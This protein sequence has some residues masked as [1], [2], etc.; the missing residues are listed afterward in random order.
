VTYLQ[1]AAVSEEK[2]ESYLKAMKDGYRGGAR[3]DGD[4]DVYN[5]L[6]WVMTEY[7]D[8]CRNQ[9]DPPR[10]QILNEIVMRAREKGIKLR[11]ENPKFWSRIYVLDA[12]LCAW[13]LGFLDAPL[14]DPGINAEL[15]AKEYASL[16]DQYSTLGE[17]DSVKKQFEFLLQVLPDS[18]QKE[19][20]GVR[21]GLKKLI[22]AVKG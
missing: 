20:K 15:L 16:I 14:A 9:I 6:N 19:V 22:A 18:K 10:L 12:D 3:L 5:A 7:V 8:M 17:A 1:N 13:L 2:I 11:D 21:T 4:I